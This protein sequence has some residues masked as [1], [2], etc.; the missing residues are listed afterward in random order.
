MPKRLHKGKRILADLGLTF[1]NST[2]TINKKNTFHKLTMGNL[3]F[4]SGS[5]LSKTKPYA[6]SFTKLRYGIA[7]VKSSLSRLRWTKV[8]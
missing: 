3:K 8:T 2:D 5:A 4:F 7:G 1:C 6:E